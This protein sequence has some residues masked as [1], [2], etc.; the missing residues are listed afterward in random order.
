MA[1]HPVTARVL[2]VGAATGAAA[3]AGETVEFV[4]TGAEPADAGSFVWAIAGRAIT[5][6]KRMRKEFLIMVDAL[7]LSPKEDKK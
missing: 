3:G 7:D 1:D 2:V 5:E 6:Q 4:S